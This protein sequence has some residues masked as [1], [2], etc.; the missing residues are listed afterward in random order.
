MTPTDPNFDARRFW[1]DTLSRD[2]DLKGTGHPGMSAA[3][4]ERC[5][6]LRGFVLDQVLA[7]H[8]VPVA[9]REVLDAG[10][11]SGFFVEH[12]LER[13]ATV[14][15]VDLTDVAVERLGGR[16]PQARFQVGDLST[17]RPDRPYDLVSC[18]DV[19]FHIVDDD[20]WDAAMTNLAD[21][22]K[23]GGWLVFTE[24]FPNEVAGGQAVHNKSRGREAYETALMA[25][26][27]AVHAERPTHHL[28]NRDL[29]LFGFLNR[30]P[31]M[32][33]RV[34]L[35]LLT[36]GLM[37][38]DGGNRLVLARRPIVGEPRADRP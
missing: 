8:R 17:W 22:V 19:L 1:Q 18:F 23:P 25:R 6:R 3:Y 9:G 37:D 26:G 2:F 28:M 30:V 31:E 16:F 20:A 34:D 32:I 4:N 21:A 14:T 33:Y 11:G 13:G 29:G 5:Y 15:G 27:L 36:T 7:K 24:H 38:H 12:F 35:A 10:C